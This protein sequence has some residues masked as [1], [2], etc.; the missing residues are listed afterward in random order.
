M[1]MRGTHAHAFVVSFYSLAD[2]KDRTLV[3]LSARGGGARRDFVAAVLQYRSELKRLGTHEGELTAFIAYA[4]AFPSG[5]LGLLDTF[6]TLET[7]VWNFVCVALAL[8]E[9][10]YRPL[11][12]RLDSG[13]L[14]YLSR[15]CRK[16]FVSVGEARG[17]DYFGRLTI[18]ASNDLSE[19][20][21]YALKEQGHAIDTFGVGTNLVTCKTQPA[22]GC[23]YKLVEVQGQPRMKVSSEPSKVTI[24]GAKEA[25]RLYNAAGEPVLDLLVQVGTAA[26]Q[27][28]KRIL[29]RHP[30]DANKRV[31]VTPTR[32]QPLHQLVWDGPVHGVKGAEVNVL[33]GY[34]SLAEVRAHVAQELQRFREDHLRRLNPT[35]YKMC[36]S[37]DLFAFMADLWLQE[38]PVPEIV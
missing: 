34:P 17:I 9:F 37:S 32:V 36:V 23:V 33:E 21:L 18:V 15:E 26:P 7:G 28:A 2:L 38:T 25:Y 14:A 24:P 19:K 16:I 29:C 20:V 3:D 11:G 1:D 8:H 12:I 31:Y 22:L 13:D 35:P 27:P 30:F 10:G 5:F 6:D 4:Q